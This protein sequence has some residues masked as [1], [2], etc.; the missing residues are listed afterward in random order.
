MNGINTGMPNRPWNSPAQPH[1]LGLGIAIL[2]ILL[3]LP[4]LEAGDWHHPMALSGG[5]YWRQRIRVAITNQ[6]A[7]TL[8]GKR[9]TLPTGTTSGAVDLT[10]EDSQSFRVVDGSGKEVLFA[11][12]SPS[13]ISIHEG[14]VP[15]GSS[16]LIPVECLPFETVVY[17]VYFDNPAAWLVPDFLR[18]PGLLNGA[19]E[20][21]SGDVPTWWKH[22]AGD[23]DHRASWVDE[24]PYSG[25][26]CLKLE[27]TPGAQNSWISTRQQSIPIEAG[28]TYTLRG[29]VKAQGVSPGA[30]TGWYVHVATPD[31]PHAIN[32]GLS[33]GGGTFEWTEVSLTFTTPPDAV[34]ASVGTMLWGTGTAWFDEVSLEAHGRSGPVD[35]HVETSSPE[36]LPLTE[37][38]RSPLW[39]DENPG[40]DVDW[41]FRAPLELL[42]L[43]A[44]P[45]RA[46]GAV[47]L[48]R[49]TSSWRDLNPESFRVVS[50]TTPLP[51]LSS[52]EE[53]MFEAFVPA[54]TR[55]YFY[56]YFS[57]D[58]RITSEVGNIEEILS[59]PD[60]KVINPSFEQVSAGIPTG[61]RIQRPDRTS[62]HGIA[63]PGLFGDHYVTFTVSHSYAGSVGWPGWIQEVPVEPGQNCFFS[64]WVKLDDVRGSVKIHAHLRDSSGQLVGN[65]PTLSIGPELSGTTGWTQLSGSF[66]IPSGATIFQIH[67]TMN[68]TGTLSHDGIVLLDGLTYPVQGPVESRETPSD[69]QIWSVP[70]VVKVFQDD[71]PPLQAQVTEIVACGGEFEPLQLGVRSREALPNL[72]IEVEAPRHTN[73]M[74]LDEFEIGTVGFVPV[75]HTSGYHRDMDRQPWERSVVMGKPATSS[76]LPSDFGTGSDGWVGWWPDPIIPAEEVSLLPDQTQPVWITFWIPPG[77]ERGD[78]FGSVQFVDDDAVVAEKKFRLHV[79]NFDLPSETATTA[80]Y[81]VRTG[82]RQVIPGKSQEEPYEKLLRLMADHRVSPERVRPEPLLA[83]SG[84]SVTAD[85]EGFDEAASF[86]LDTLGVPQIYTPS[87]FNIFGWANPPKVCFGESPYPGQSPYAG[88][89][90]SVLR[91]E[92]KAAYQSALDDFWSHIKEKGWSK[93]FVL[94]IADEPHYWEDGIIEQMKALCDMVHEVDEDIPIYSS[95]WSHVPEW[96]G[97]LD[98]WGIGHFGVV[99]P[100]KIAQLLAAG[101]RVWFTTDGH[102]C[103]D[104]P[105]CAIE[106]LLPHI[107]YHYDVEGYE[108]WGV[109]WLSD[110][111][112]WRFGWHSRVNLTLNPEEPVHSVIYPNGDGYLV[113]PGAPVGLDQ[114]V[115]TIR[116]AQAREGVEDYALLA[117]LEARIGEAHAANL[118]VGEAERALQAIAS[119][120]SIP[121]PSGRWSSELLP[122]PEA[123]YEAR[124]RVGEAIER[125]DYALRR[126]KGPSRGSVRSHIP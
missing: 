113:Y 4:S 79:W 40:D 68:A 13:G 69:I 96:D 34:D 120:V 15:E 7:Q 53:L 33:A 18:P 24:S 19:V 100:E 9:I 55:R 54:H 88:A 3:S 29:W 47:N 83:V 97:Y 14:P 70:A 36:S 27:V 89:D 37:M 72:R 123:L 63:G 117:L 61:W 94:Y 98:V 84:D 49:F 125:I 107:A 126:C 110:Y 35:F 73:G 85:Y 23:F 111:D 59:G 20:E 42:N 48:R 77:T 67:L 103:I 62:S 10:G 122:S 93:R 38:D 87:V 65:N 50:G 30:S 46:Q 56:L 81:D 75:A 31:D 91:S 25:Q 2:A 82:F 90:R 102:M 115:P 112:P 114:A 124:K 12:S 57:S 106:R 6:T 104:T 58:P 1:P 16:L 121:G 51:L 41:Y 80:I 108:F 105:Y 32:R 118:N 109:D 45:L 116:L 74:T 99:P 92:Y 26:K 64:G 86:L 17:W 76:L 66:S 22:D 8:V 95:V 21:G 78:Y 119:L 11:L 5:D 28:R 43:G 71:H 101:D 60:N 52:G 44:G 39:F